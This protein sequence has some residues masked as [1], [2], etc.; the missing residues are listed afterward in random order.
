MSESKP[1]CQAI[2]AAI[3]SGTIEVSDQKQPARRA[4]QA[5]MAEKWAI[6]PD[7]LET[8]MQVAERTNESPEAVTAKLGRPLENTRS[9]E[10]RNGTAI[11]PVTGPVFRYANLMTEVSGA[12]S[13][14][15]LAKDFSTALNDNMIEQIVLDI[16]SPGG[17]VTGVNEFA[18]MIYEARGKVP[19]I[20][21]VSGMGASAAY[22]IASAADEIVLD[23]T[24][25]VGS[26]GVVSTIDARKQDGI[27]EIVSSQSPNKR[28]DVSTDY[29]RAQ[30]QKTVD[31]LADVFIDAV[32]RNRG[33]D[34]A[35]VLE[36]YG[37][38]DVF[39]GEQAVEAGMADRVGSLE[40][41]IAGVSGSTSD[42]VI[43]MSEKTETPEITRDFIAHEHP[44]VAEAF[45][46]EGAEAAYKEAFNAGAQSERERIQAVED[47]LVPGHE[48][49]IAAMKFDG[50]TSGPEAAVA[51]IK[52]EKAHMAATKEA[53]EAD[54]VEP[55][56][57][58]DPAVK[59]S[60]NLPLEEQCAAAWK[61]DPAL[62]SEFMDD[63]DAY[64]AFEKA[65]AAGIVKQLRK[66]G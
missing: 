58:A 57:P 55:V 38:G 63:F 39:V 42:E 14:E 26:V 34:R 28:P 18:N 2:N 11:I 33:I 47:Q 51:I 36:Q 52:A 41:L 30:V 43:T 62:R 21:Y 59:V 44:A 25:M 8:I 53:R 9:V 35:S 27:V 22:W 54:A 23:D 7:A 6:L 3:N 61:H 10:I 65:D 4:M 50:K 31:A 37:Q 45:R 5:I 24:A 48:D 1:L 15:V 16:D 66:E 20:A 12:T 40:S 46:K 32:A 49:L 13:I 60:S 29:G 19:I 64:L 17:Q 56:A